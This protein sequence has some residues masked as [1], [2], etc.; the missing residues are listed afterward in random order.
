MKNKAKKLNNKLKK[1]KK[2]VFLFIIF[3]IIFLLLLA[4]KLY[5]G[6]TKKIVRE[7]AVAGTWYPG[8]EDNLNELIEYFLNRAKTTKINKTIK[9][10]IVP[11]AGYRFS[12]IVAAYGFNQ[13]NGK[14]ETVIVL[15]PSHH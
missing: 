2:K 14:Y 9:A 6:E 10:L 3:S 4:Y 5:N 12:G 8:S 13:L 11:H 7:P 15:G 1:I